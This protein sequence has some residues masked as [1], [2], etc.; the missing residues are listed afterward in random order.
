[1][2]VRIHLWWLATVLTGLIFLATATATAEKPAIV[3]VA[4]GASAKA[5]DTYKYIG[6][7]VKERFPD[8]DIRWAY[9]STSDKSMAEQQQEFPDLTRALADLK[10]AG[11]TRVAVQSLDVIPGEEWE[12]LGKISQEIPGLKIALG[13]PL[14]S[15]L[16]DRKRLLDALAKEF[17][18]DSKD[19]AV[20]LVSPGSTDPAGMRENLSLYTLM[21]SKLKGKNVFF[22]VVEGP[23]AIKNALG[24]LKRSTA[25]KVT[26]LP[27]LL[28]T[29]DPFVKALMGDKDSIKS[30]LLAARPYEIQAID[31][32]LGANDGVIHIYLDH[33]AG[34]L[35]TFVEKKKEKKPKK[36]KK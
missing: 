24:G 22:G 27:L 19:H 26:I 35:D 28:L 11:L 18:P 3:L 8:H 9:T 12:K 31:K 15:S 34:A 29:G 21:L 13:K 20:L 2:I 17:P 36:G 5:A 30:D 1:M 6:D 32:G 25:G 33:L 23:P 16:A 7:K 14:L 4:P 10:A